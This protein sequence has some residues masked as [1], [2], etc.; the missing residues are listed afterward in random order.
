MDIIGSLQ[1]GPAEWTAERAAKA[2]EGQGAE[3][4]TEQAEHAQPPAPGPHHEGQG[5]P[6]GEV[7]QLLIEIHPEPEADHHQQLGQNRHHI[8][9]GSIV[10]EQQHGNQ[11]QA[12]HLPVDAEQTLQGPLLTH[13]R[14]DEQDQWQ[15]N[16]EQGRQAVVEPD[17]SAI[18]QQ[19]RHATG[20][21]ASRH[22]PRVRC[23]QG[24]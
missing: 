17:E 9:Q 21:S 19:V 10:R 16:R 22:Y 14:P 11:Q 6:G 4:S 23:T 1:P 15:T 20:G 2:A 18:E 3:A 12:G 7:S 13:G 5:P 24:L 8:P